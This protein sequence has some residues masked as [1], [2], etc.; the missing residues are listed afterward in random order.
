M[1][2]PWACRPA[3]AT[4][5]GSVAVANGA[6]HWSNVSVGG[7]TVL[8]ATSQSLLY[9]AKNNSGHHR[10]TTGSTDVERVRITQAGDVG[11]GTITPS[12]RLHVVGGNATFGSHVLV[13]GNGTVTG[14]L[15][16]TGTISS[17]GSDVMIA[18]NFIPRTTGTY[19]LGN[20]DYGWHQQWYAADIFRPRENH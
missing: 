3:P 12:S 7:D 4:P 15:V 5:S 1:V 17:T 8:M 18:D 10:F 6:A 13:S 16:V 20:A 19:I 14:N 11:I 9:S 2:N